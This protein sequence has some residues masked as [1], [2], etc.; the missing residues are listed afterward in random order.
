MILFALS[1]DI[2]TERSQSSSDNQISHWI[3][4]EPNSL[5]ENQSHGD[6]RVEICK[7]FENRQE[8]NGSL[9]KRIPVPEDLSIE[10]Q[11]A[12]FQLDK[13]QSPPLEDLPVVNHDDDK[14]E[15]SPD[16]FR[17][18][19]SYHFVNPFV[20]FPNS[21]QKYSDIREVD[22]DASSGARTIDTNNRETTY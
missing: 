19:F 1:S 5:E 20:L 8:F 18:E 11:N 12:S 15:S 4:T 9:T 2:Q 3:I 7:G 21:N 10:I 22:C 17:N 6:D 14:V 13:D 16:D